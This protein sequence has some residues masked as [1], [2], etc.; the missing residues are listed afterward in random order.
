MVNI[1]HLAAAIAV[2]ASTWASAA[3]V[4]GNEL[5]AK[6]EGS[7]QDRNMAAAYIAGVHDAVEGTVVCA[8][9]IQLQQAMDMVY[10][11]LKAVP[12]ERHRSADTYVVATL[13]AQWPC[14]AS[15]TK[16]SNKST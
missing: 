12:E 13:A 7:A 4:T 5:L 11:V 9:G 1:K 10:Q 8:P 2:T 6:L 15:P 3:F 16:P 14:K